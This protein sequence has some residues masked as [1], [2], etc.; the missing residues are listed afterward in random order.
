[1]VLPRPK[2]CGKEATLP[3]LIKT[4]RVIVMK[5][6]KKK[7]LACVY[8]G[9]DIARAK[10]DVCVLDDQGMRL[11]NFQISNSL[12]GFHQLIEALMGYDDPIFG[13]EST[14][15]Y[16]GNL[17]H[18][19]NQINAQV[20]ITNPFYVARLRD[21]FSKTV[22]NDDIALYVIALA[23]RMNVLKDSQKDDKYIFLQDL[24]ERLYDL[25]DRKTAL[26]NQLRSTLIQVFP[27]IDNFFTDITCHAALA[28]LEEWQTADTLLIVS[29]ERIHQVIKR[30]KGRLSNQRI[31]ELQIDCKVAS[32]WKTTVVHQK[33]ILSQVAE[34]QL[35][36][37]QIKEIEGAIDE[38][39]SQFGTEL[40]LLQSVPGIG[41]KVAHQFLAIV[42]DVKRFDPTGDRQG[43]K[44]LSSFLGFGIV[45]YSSGTVSYKKGMSKR[46]NGRLRGMLYMSGLVA[47][48]CDDDLKAYYESYI[49]RSGSGKKRINALGHTLARRC[50][51]VLKSGQP[52]NASIPKH[53]SLLTFEATSEVN[54]ATSA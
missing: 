22:K 14:G 8:V 20:V 33:I 12:P 36:K 24:L 35:L 4:L 28:I 19:L 30:H 23:L 45:E 2:A 54:I 26:S 38:Y 10:I 9:L 7:S 39:C 41:K 42:G 13:L 40:A 32:G 43:A 11:K 49:A 52:Y 47:L 3:T 16:G 37:Q 53:E 50:Y 48:R 1:M 27:E 18:F 31:T 34:L 21:A 46:G 6:K 51:G 5:I 17:S 44:R 29:D 25:T 15:P